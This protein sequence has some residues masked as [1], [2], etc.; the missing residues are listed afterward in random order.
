[1]VKSAGF[2]RNRAYDTT[3]PAFCQAFFVIFV[4]FRQKDEYFIENRGIIV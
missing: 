2:V 4:D 1:M 3:F